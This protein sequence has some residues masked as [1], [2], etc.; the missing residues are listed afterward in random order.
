MVTLYFNVRE[1]A[2]PGRVLEVTL[3]ERTFAFPHVLNWLHVRGSPADGPPVT[4]DVAPLLVAHG[5]LRVAAETTLSGDVN[6]NG[7]VDLTDPVVL[8]GELFLDSRG[9]ICA[10]AADFNAD[11]TLNVT[12]AVAILNHLFLGGP[13]WRE[14]VD[15][16]AASE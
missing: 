3:E 10:E 9:A 13:R 7:T 5:L 8:L 11:G 12:D 1:S 6:V 14:E 2:P 4:V 15:C 16:A